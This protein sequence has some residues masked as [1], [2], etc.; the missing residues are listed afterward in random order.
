MVSVMGYFSRR[1]F[2]MTTS[3]AMFAAAAPGSASSSAHDASSSHRTLVLIAS[4]A[5]DGILFYEWDGSTGELKPA[6]VAAK[7]PKVAWLAF[8]HGHEYVYS[9]SE[10]DE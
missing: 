6:G 2:L 5:P 1:E 10:L 7:V 8:S 4:S 9:A 3:A